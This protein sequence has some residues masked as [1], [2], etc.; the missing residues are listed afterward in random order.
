MLIV[1]F[2][3][4]EKYPVFIQLNVPILIESSLV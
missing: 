1:L 4:V 3:R 2:T